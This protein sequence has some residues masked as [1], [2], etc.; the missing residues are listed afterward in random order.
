MKASK[1]Y[2]ISI[3]DESRLRQIVS[4]RVRPYMLWGG[5]ALALLLLLFL[6]GVV[7]VA[8]P[9]R[10]L[11]PGY[12][13]ENER[14][15]AEKD[16]LRLDSIKIISDR[17]TQYLSN[18]LTVFD[19]DRIPGDSALSSPIPN[20]LTPDS[21][22]PASPKEIEFLNRMKDREKFNVSM[23]APISADQM[24]FYPPGSGAVVASR[25]QEVVKAQIVTPKGSPVCAIADGRVISLQNP[26]PEGGAAIVIHHDNGFVS[27]YSHIGTPAVGSGSQVEGGSVIAHGPGSGAASP[28]WFYLELWYDGTPIPPAKYIEGHSSR[29]SEESDEPYVLSGRPMGR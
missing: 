3:Y 24:R 25:S 20:E 21:L 18:I 1:R 12:L 5:S 9:L 27:R 15:A 7:I 13:K 14:S 23:L 11:M 29:P 16:A 8:T 17:N 6:A 28:G 22:L 19:T 2:R 10:T 26:A 4:V